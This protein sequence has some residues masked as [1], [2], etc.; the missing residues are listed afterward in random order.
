MSNIL[1][2]VVLSAESACLYKLSNSLNSLSIGAVN[3]V[4]IFVACKTKAKVLIISFIFILRM[5]RT[6]H[7]GRNIAAYFALKDN[8]CKFE[9]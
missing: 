7:S 1:L 6:L 3:E 8:L 2:N 5:L 4:C 9:V